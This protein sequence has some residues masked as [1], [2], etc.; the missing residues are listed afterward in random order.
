MKAY[1]ERLKTLLAAY[2]RAA[3]STETGNAPLTR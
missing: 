2:R 3:N 1:R